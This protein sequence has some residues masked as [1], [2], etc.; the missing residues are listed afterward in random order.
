LILASGSPRRQELLR[1]AGL[2]FTVLKPE[3]DERPLKGE[4]AD[5]YVLRLA[6]EKAVAAASLLDGKPALVLAA[7]TTVALGGKLLGKPAHRRESEKM[8]RL[9]SGRVHEVFTGVSL[10][11]VEDGLGLRFSVRTEVEFAKLTPAQIRWYAG[12][13][14]PYDK[15]GGYAIQGLAGAFVR[16]IEGSYSN[17]VGLPVAEVLEHLSELGHP[18]PWSRR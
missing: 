5:R 6:A 18:L 10:L 15:A 16:G 1:L 11:S 3:I 8:L 9:L 2:E 13:R 12:T 4:R 7:D 14:E 17:V